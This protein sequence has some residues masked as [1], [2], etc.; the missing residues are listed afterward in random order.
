MR[1]I[2]KY[3]ETIIEKYNG[4]PVGLATIAAS[5][6][7]EPGYHYGSGG[8]IPFATGIHRTHSTRQGGDPVGVRTFEDSLR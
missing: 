1:W 7:E 4:G 3:C 2:E 6:S 5:I 8:T